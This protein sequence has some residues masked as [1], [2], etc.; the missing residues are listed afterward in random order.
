MRLIAKVNCHVG[1][2]MPRISNILA[3]RLRSAASLQASMALI[4]VSTTK[5][6]QIGCDPSAQLDLPLI[7]Q[8]T[9][10]LHRSLLS[11][12]EAILLAQQPVDLSLGD[13]PGAQAPKEQL[14]SG[15]RLVTKLLHPGCWAGL[16]RALGPLVTALKHRRARAGMDVRRAS[17]CLI[18]LAMIDGLLSVP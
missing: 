3:M 6:H 14:T 10:S 8:A 11:P 2:R 1:L 12:G 9:Q 16:S 4:W 13:H 15:H 5:W 18:R 7:E 17:H